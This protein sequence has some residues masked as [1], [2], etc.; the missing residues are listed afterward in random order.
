MIISLAA[1]DLFNR[2]HVDQQHE[3]QEFY[4][5]ML[6]H[7]LRSIQDMRQILCSSK[8]LDDTYNSISQCER[9][10]LLM[11]VMLHSLIEIATN[12]TSEWAIH[13]LGGLSMVKRY[14][15]K[16][17][18]P[19]VY[20][21]VTD[22]FSLSEAFLATTGT[23]LEIEDLNGWLVPQRKSMFPVLRSMHGRSQ[24]NP[25]TG[26]SSELIQNITLITSTIQRHSGAGSDRTSAAFMRT[27]LQAVENRL[28]ELEQW[29]EDSDMESLIYL[30]A[31]AF[32]AAAWVYLRVAQCGCDAEE[33]QKE[34]MPKL[35]EAIRRVHQR[36]GALVGSVPYPLWALFIAACLA[37]E[38]ERVQVLDWFEELKARRSLSNVS[39][40]MEA[41]MMVWKQHDLNMGGYELAADTYDREGILPP[42]TAE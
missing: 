34:L 25:Y 30:N 35:F 23:E 26:L 37:P 9:D 15:H 21:F 33:I 7:K 22:H 6:Q 38:H 10:G 1:H 19:E 3:R 12:S 39:S 40:T 5:S 2:T 14:G 42:R 31:A 27:E 4:S 36:Q 41:A 11:A 16:P 13:T 20:R 32:E 17:F 8:G 18:S 24:I 28:S 29:S